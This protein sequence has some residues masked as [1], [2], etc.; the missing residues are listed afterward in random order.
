MRCGASR[1]PELVSFQV[2][3]SRWPHTFFLFLDVVYRAFIIG[4]HYE[5]V[6]H[7]FHTLFEEELAGEAFAWILQAYRDPLEQFRQE[8]QARAESEAFK[9]LYDAMTRVY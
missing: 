1:A 3:F 9:R 6:L 4:G 2:R 5:E 7:G 8:K